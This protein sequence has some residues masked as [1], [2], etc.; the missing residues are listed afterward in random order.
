MHDVTLMWTFMQTFMQT[1]MW[2][3]KLVQCWTV[4]WAS[5]ASWALAHFNIQCGRLVVRLMHCICCVYN[6][7]IHDIVIILWHCIVLLWL[8]TQYQ[9]YYIYNLGTKPEL[10]ETLQEL[11]PHAAN[12]KIIGSLLGIEKHVLDKIKAEEEGIINC[13]HEM[14]SEWQKRVTPPPTWTILADAIESI[15]KS[16]AQDIRDRCVKR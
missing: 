11:I 13:L 16:K 10:K 5:L 14:L 12:W 15:D 7:V 1:F 2:N 3:V 4:E 8:Q 9:C 6:G